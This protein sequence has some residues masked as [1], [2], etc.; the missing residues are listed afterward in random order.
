MVTAAQAT[1]YDMTSN[2]LS[3]YANSA[4]VTAVGTASGPATWGTGGVWAAGE[5][6]S[7]WVNGE[8]TV[9]TNNY[10]TPTSNTYGSPQGFTTYY[11]PT[12]G[13]QTNGA[14]V[15]ATYMYTVPFTTYQFNPGQTIHQAV[16]TTFTEQ[17]ASGHPAEKNGG[18]DSTTPGLPTGFTSGGASSGTVTEITH[19]ETPSG[20][21]AIGFTTTGY[22]PQ[23]SYQ[24][25][26]GSQQAETAG[27]FYNY[28]SSD[29]STKLA[30]LNMPSSSTTDLL[31]TNNLFGPAYVA[32]T[33]PAN[34]E[35]NSIN[36]T[37][38]DIGTVKPSDGDP[39]YYVATSTGGPTAPIFAAYNYAATG[40]ANGSQYAATSFTNDTTSIPG[41][42]IQTPTG[43]VPTLM[44]STYSAEGVLGL[45]WISGSFA[46][47][48][49]EVIFFVND[50]GR[51]QFQSHGNHTGGGGIDALAMGATV[52][53]TAVPEPSTCVLFGMAGVGLAFAAW[54]RRR[55]TT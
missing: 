50:P 53:F 52:D 46:V 42:V 29:T 31:T 39:G 49:G 5:M 37:V 35:V 8:G 12:T 26:D 44:A 6:S 3:T 20:T 10:P 18:A 54:K 1:T 33:A 47:T 19:I 36:T 23:G 43:T 2:W 24:D 21:T 17:I 51:N 13:F 30:G 32:W 15:Q 40:T 4:A 34:G 9:Q 38:Y 27:I 28:G 22:D 14:T 11:L 7:N 25:G 16:G 41:S 55:V 45:Q 48:A